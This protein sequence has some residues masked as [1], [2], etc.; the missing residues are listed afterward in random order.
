MLTR[1]RVFRWDLP[2]IFNHDNGHATEFMLVFMTKAKKIE[3]VQIKMP[4][5]VTTSRFSIFSPGGALRHTSARTKVPD[6]Q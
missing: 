3:Y 6:Y 5:N 4:I 1:Y 2:E